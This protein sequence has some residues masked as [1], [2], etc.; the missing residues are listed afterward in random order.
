MAAQ[1]RYGSREDAEEAMQQF[2]RAPEEKAA[3]RALEELLE[4]HAAPVIKAVLLRKLQVHLD[5]MRRLDRSLLAAQ[6]ERHAPPKTQAELDAEDLYQDALV[7]LAQKL[8]SLRES[9]DAA[10]IENF[11]AYVAQTTYHVLAMHLRQKYPERHRLRNQLLY[12]LEG[13]SRVTG[14]A[15]WEG[16]EADERLC[17]FADW[18]GTR[19]SRSSQYG[20]WLNDPRAF[21]SALRPGEDMARM[22][23]PD[24]LARLFDW[25]GG[26]MEVDDVING[27][28]ELLEVKK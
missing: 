26:P 18:K 12:L 7:S 15:V 9:P 16:R 2:L 13:R 14:F 10:R 17:G 11:P 3:T 1:S 6:S 25:I 5:W 28:A 21:L 19:R 4:S 27:L 24:L 23:L 8:W 20:E 22:R